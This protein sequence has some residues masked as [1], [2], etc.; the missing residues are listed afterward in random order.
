MLGLRSPFQYVLDIHDR[1]LSSGHS[2]NHEVALKLMSFLTEG[3]ALHA[4]QLGGA[5]RA[6]AEAEIR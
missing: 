5:T 2:P 3:A 1:D 6:I 4:F